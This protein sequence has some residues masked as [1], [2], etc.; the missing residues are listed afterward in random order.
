MSFIVWSLILV[1]SKIV[2]TNSGEKKFM[3]LE[4][5]IEIKVKALFAINASIYILQ[6][7]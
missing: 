1:Y 3:K 6:K 2:K 7:R 5:F 4:Y